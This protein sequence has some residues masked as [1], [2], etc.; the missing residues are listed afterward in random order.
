[1]SSHNKQSGFTVTELLIVMMISSFLLITLYLFTSSSVNSF[2]QLQAD[3]LAH[4]KLADG[5]FRVIRVIRGMNYIESANTDT[6]TAYSY[7]APNDQ[8]TSKIRYYL[9]GTQDKL[10]AEV[11]PMTADYPTG[12][13]ITAQTKTVTIIDKFYKVAG[14]PTFVYYDANYDELASPV[15]DLQSI[16][17]ISV[18]LQVKKYDSNANDYVSSKVTVSLRNRKSNL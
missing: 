15:T 8:Y 17:N 13:L 3:G 16:K 11:T 5:S 7:F 10:L 1:M 9:N 14:V 6:I 12:T 2:M 18:Q 4:S